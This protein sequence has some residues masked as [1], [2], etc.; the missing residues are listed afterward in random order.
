MTDRDLIPVPVRT[1]RILVWAASRKAADHCASSV[2]GLLTG[3][4]LHRTSSRHVE[5]SLE[6]AKLLPPAQ[7]TGDTALDVLAC[8]TI[9]MD[10]SDD[11]EKA[12]GA[13]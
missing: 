2:R 3:K 5:A 7:S 8:I 1:L 11:Q 13:P 10:M 4:E 9:S 12:E 6:V